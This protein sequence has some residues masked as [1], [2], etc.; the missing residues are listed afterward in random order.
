[1]RLTIKLFT[2]TSGRWM[3]INSKGT[4]NLS[5]PADA[6]DIPCRNIH[7]HGN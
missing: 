1:M 3:T 4:C 7:K 6:G 5:T 2:V